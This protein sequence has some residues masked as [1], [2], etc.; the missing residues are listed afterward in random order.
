MVAGFR[1][2]HSDRENKSNRLAELEFGPIS[3]AFRRRQWR[4]SAFAL[5]QQSPLREALQ[6]PAAMIVV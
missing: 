5:A 6:K 2:L 4:L 3:I 1:I